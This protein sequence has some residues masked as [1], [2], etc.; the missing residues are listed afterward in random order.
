MWNR[1]ESERMIIKNIKIEMEDGL[2]SYFEA[3]KVLNDKIRKMEACNE[4]YPESG[5]KWVGK[6][7]SNRE[8]ETGEM[9]ECQ[10]GWKPIREGGVR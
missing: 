1:M 10:G 8:V 7:K 2:A 5:S 3:K 6:H 4:D 9:R